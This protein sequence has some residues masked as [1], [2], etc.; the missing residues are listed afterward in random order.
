MTIRLQGFGGEIPR[1]DP[2]YLPQ[3]AAAEAM[4]AAMRGGSLTPFRQSTAQEHLFPSSR[5]SIYLH[6]VEWLG[7]S[8]DTDVVP[9]PVATDRLY[10][11][12]G[13][14]QPTM[15][16]SGNEVPLRLPLPSTAPTIARTGTLDPETAEYV[17]Y[18]FT[19]VTSLGEE[20]GPSPLSNM[21]QWSPG[22]GID[23]TGLPTT[24]PVADRFISGKR[25]YRSVTSTSGITDLYYVGEVA[26]PAASWA[27]NMATDPPAEPIPTK[28]F[29]PVPINL[30][31]LTALPNGMMAGFAGKEV[32]FCEPYQPHAWPD[33][34]RQ[35]VND[36]I[37]GLAAFGTT[38]AVL[39]T[40]QP[41]ILQGMHPEQMAMQKVEV[42]FPCMSKLGIV[43]L[44]YSAV[45]PSTDGLVAVSESGAQLI[46]KGLWTREQWQAMQPTT[47]VAAR[48]GDLY[49]F[50]FTPPSGG[51]NKHVILLDPQSPDT[52]IMRSSI[53]PRSIYT[54][55]ESGQT[56]FLAAGGQTVR[57]FDS[58]A[59]EK[60]N[61]RWRSKPI[62]LDYPTSYGA[63]RIDTDGN[64]DETVE[65]R[66]YADGS[67][68][69][70]VTRANRDERLPSGAWQTWQI[71]LYGTAT[72]IRATIAKTF[73]ELNG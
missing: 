55:I 36:T 38:L 21:V 48:F 33:A 35:T 53:Q 26:V 42:P 54:H 68:I 32:Y 72:V 59:E 29:R 13:S 41:Y 4:N 20:S 11:S 10:I 31:G 23:V 28:D 49:G 45:Y 69:R 44:G 17:R 66:V 50:T 58:P 63:I 2:F 65:A 39:T 5:Q 9:G 51:L 47:M 15:W 61:Y 34:Y 24:P 12:H 16:I 52:G 27:H 46:S 14:G 56:Y 40:G 18:A 7:W 22:N 3:T 25:I 71:E 70:T 60:H 19:W 30:R 37:I 1:T 43:D 73:L 67:L 64:P 62:R 8:H 6:G 57:A